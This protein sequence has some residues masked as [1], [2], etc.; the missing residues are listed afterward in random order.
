MA[1]SPPLTPTTPTIV[2]PKRLMN[3]TV[4]NSHV[5]RERASQL[6]IDTGSPMPSLSE[7]A[8]VTHLGLFM[9]RRGKTPAT[10]ATPNGSREEFCSPQS[11]TSKRASLEFRLH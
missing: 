3:V 11:A 4:D 1:D 5:T 6:L 10:P 2:V 7:R 8:K 9:N